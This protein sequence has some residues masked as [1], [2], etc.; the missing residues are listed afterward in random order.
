MGN[1]TCRRPLKRTYNILFAN[2]KF[3]GHGSF[4]SFDISDFRAGMLHAM[5][6]LFVF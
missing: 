4:G 3:A 2:I 1:L 6:K 5:R